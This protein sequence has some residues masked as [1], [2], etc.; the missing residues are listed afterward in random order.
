MNALRTF[1]ATIALVAS[2]HAAALE[3]IANG[4]FESGF[5][6]WTLVDQVGSEPGFA[7][8]TGTASPVLGFPVPPPPE[9]VQAAMTDAAGPGSHLL[10]Q[11]FVVPALVSNAMLTV[12]LYVNNQ[13]IDFF[14]P[15]HLDFAT[16]DLNQQARVDILVAGADP[17]SVAAGDVLFNAFATVSGDPLTV[18]Y[19]TYTFDL[20]ALLG[21]N[22][23]QSLRLRFAEVDNVN[24]FNFGVDA[25]S[26][27]VDEQRVP[28]PATWLLV[29]LAAV[30]ALRFTR[31]ERR[32]A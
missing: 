3:L 11:D 12:M 23:G 1:A 15:A 9:G 29:A 24:L 21:A 25:V 14:A 16:A 27:V 7:L 5:T 28:E 30:T 10:Y 4:G 22:L 19:L 2:T 13:A 17:F 6:G 26:L 31:R 20:T 18:G 8:Q 32:R